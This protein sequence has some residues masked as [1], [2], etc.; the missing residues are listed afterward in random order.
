QIEQL[1][2]VE[3]HRASAYTTPSSRSNAARRAFAT[4]GGGLPEGRRVN[5]GRPSRAPR[6]AHVGFGRGRECPAPPEPLPHIPPRPLPPLPG[7]GGG[8][9]PDPAPTPRPRF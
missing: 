6:P 7:G 3:L 1:W 2:F 5:V 9:R 8:R 4:A